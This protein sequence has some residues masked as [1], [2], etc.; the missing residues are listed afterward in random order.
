MKKLVSLVLAVLMLVTVIG[1]SPTVSAENVEYTS[2][3]ED[4]GKKYWSEFY[5]KNKNIQIVKSGDWYYA[6][7]FNSYRYT[8]CGYSG[9]E[10]EI[11]IPSKLNGERIYAISE[12][13]ILTDS[14]KTIRIPKEIAY[15]DGQYES[16]D[17]NTYVDRHDYYDAVNEMPSPIFEGESQ[18]EN[19]IV[20]SANT[21]YSSLDGVLFTK[22]FIRLIYYPSGKTSTKYVVP[23]MVKYITNAAF[24]AAMNLKSLTITPNVSDLGYYSVPR[25]GLEELRFINKLLPRYDYYLGWT[26]ADD[27]SRVKYIPG[28]PDAVIYC[29]KD[30]KLY[31][32]YSKM[33]YKYK[34]LKILPNYKKTLIK[35]KG[36]WYLCYAG[37]KFSETTFVKFKDKWFYVVDGVWD[38]T[39][40]ILFKYRDKWFYVK[41]GKWDSRAKTLI[42]YQGK[43]FYIKNGKWCK[44]TT[45]V[46]YNGKSF[47]VKNGKVDFDFS[48][49]KKINGK[50]Y[51]IKNGKVV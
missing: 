7:N 45:V 42:K 26:H 44:D 48:G 29:M 34:E 18:V 19:I 20:D 24:A 51:K 21:H 31:D 17:S 15:I 46:R 16:A 30:S 36:K 50:T 40:T 1:T 49:S 9:E 14:V 41:N 6:V 2:V 12:F 27:L 23:D 28:L 8:V 11:I 22:N 33:S 39:K 25:K 47:Y 13:Y 38:K 32:I 5:K 10:S 35:D 37:Y 43:W 4:F 3:T